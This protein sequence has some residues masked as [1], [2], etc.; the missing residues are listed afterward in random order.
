MVV[1]V[2]CSSG[3]ADK[4]INISLTPSYHHYHYH[5]PFYCHYPFFIK[6]GLEMYT[7]QLL[8]WDASDWK[9]WRFLDHEIVKRFIKG[10]SKV[11]SV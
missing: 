3:G 1:V 4:R 10:M 2:V 11:K 5:Y 6:Q 9:R 8:E 7:N